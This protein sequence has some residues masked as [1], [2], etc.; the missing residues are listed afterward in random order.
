MVI[1]FAGLR[2]IQEEAMTKRVG[3][4]RGI[5]LVVILQVGAKTYHFIPTYTFFFPKTLLRE[6]LII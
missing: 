6:R 2:Q 5:Q 1:F 3:F 4:I